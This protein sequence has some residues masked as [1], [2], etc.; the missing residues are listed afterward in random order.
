[1]THKVPRGRFLW[2]ELLTTDPGAAQ[3]FYTQLVGWDTTSWRAG[4]EPYTLWTSG[5][6]RI[7]GLM[8]LP[9]QATAIGTPPHWLGYVST[10]DADATVAAAVKLGARTLM[11]AMDVPDVGRVA[12]IG[13][14]QGAVIGLY[15]PQEASADEDAPPV[16]GEI[17]WHELVTTDHFAAFP[18]YS[19]LFGWNKSEVMDMGEM[20]LYQMYGRNG[21]TLGGMFNKPKQMDGPA[22][23]LYYIHVGDVRR[24]AKTVEALGGQVLNGPMEVPGGDLIAQCLDPQGA[25]FALHSPQVT[26]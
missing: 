7:G 10:P 11:P 26:G 2:Y 9:P 14:P 25:A 23:W 24:A 18:F 5:E 20:G 1:M 6:R 22:A 15:T 19:A 3:R 12:V 16:I 8:K 21:R 17:A 13:D 4:D